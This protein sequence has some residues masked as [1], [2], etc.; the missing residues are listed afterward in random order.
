MVPAS[1]G[2]VFA[3]MDGPGSSV[4]FLHLLLIHAKEWFASTKADV[5]KENVY[6]PLV[7]QGTIAM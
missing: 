2:N 5:K 4:M 7:G 6:A 1:R 3:V